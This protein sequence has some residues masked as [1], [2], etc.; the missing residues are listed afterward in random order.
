MNTVSRN[1]VSKLFPRRKDWCHKGDFGNVLIIGGSKKYSGSPGL[2]AM[3]AYRSGADLV[4][5]AAPK[6]AAD[7]VASFSPDFIAYPLDGDYLNSKHVNDLVGLSKNADSVVIGGGL[8]RQKETIKAIIDFLD[9][10]HLPCVVDADALFA[11]AQKTDII[12]NNWILT[13]HTREFKELTKEEPK[14]NVD[15]RTRLVKYFSSKFGTTILLK[16]YMDVVSDGGDVFLNKSGDP[17]MT[18]GGTGDTLAGICG[19]LLARGARPLDAACAGAYINGTAGSLAAK[20]FGEGMAATDL[21][22]MIP[23]AIK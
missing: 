9:K 13:P 2:S 10:I 11:I 4:T 23:R 22:G 6:R 7:I 1:Q 20:M 8:D 15:D 18:K 5:V 14:L 3:S 19:A 21:I 16:G 17:C 12:K